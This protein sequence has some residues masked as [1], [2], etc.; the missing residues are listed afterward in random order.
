MTAAQALRTMKIL[1]YKH[2]DDGQAWLE[3]LARRLP[4]AEIRRWSDGDLAAADYALVWKPPAEVLSRP[5]LKAVFNLGAGVDALLGFLQRQ[6]DLLPAQV[7]IIKIDDAGMGQQMVQYVSYAV[8]R[9]FRRMHDYRRQQDQGAW[10]PL[11]PRRQSD[12]RVGVLGAGALGSQVARALRDAGFPVRTWTRR[13]N[14]LPGT[15]NFAG[16]ARKDAFLQGLSAVINMLPLTPDTENLLDR[17]CFSQLAQAAL[18]VNVARGAHL[19]EADLLQALGS[20]QVS[21]AM[22]DVFRDEPLPAGHPFWS[23]PAIDITPH[24]SA[25]TMLDESVAQIAE[26]IETLERGGQVEGI[27]DRSCGY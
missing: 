10:L 6:P 5:G 26:R 27:V 23:H 2:N 8:L 22:L 20:G 13:P 18:V 3:Q 11:P 1:F 24:I 4:Q 17:H 21:M 7:P 12:Y 9:H 16:A 19:V 14:A 15:D 25:I